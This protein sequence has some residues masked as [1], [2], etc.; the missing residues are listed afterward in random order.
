MPP[1]V[2][3]VDDS[4][5][6]RMDLGDAFEGAGFSP[7]LAS[8][9][10]ESR[11]ALE[12]RPYALVVLDVM[13]PDGDGLDLLREVKMG[14]PS[15]PVMLL[16]SEAEVAARLRG[17]RTGADEYVGKPYDMSYVL[18]RARQLIRRTSPRPESGGQILI[19]DDS[20]TFREQLRETLEGAGY[21]V[22]LSESGEEALHIAV[23]ARPAVIV[24]D[25]V[26]PGIDGATFIRRVREDAL[27]RRTP[28]ILLTASEGKGEVLALDSGANA[29]MQKDA[30][31]AQVL[32]R[33]GAVLRP[34]S[35]AQSSSHDASLHGPKKI[36]A[37]D[38]SM[39]YLQEI[40]TQLRRDGFHVVL[41]ASGEEAL[42]LL[43]ESEVDCILLDVLMP[44]LSGFETCRRIKADPRWRDVP[45]IMHTARD[46]QGSMVEGIDAGADD[47]VTKS[48]DFQV[49]RARL[50]AQL[51]RRQFEYE[52]RD[53]RETQIE[54][55]LE[56]AES[57]AQRELADSRAELLLEL[58]EKSKAL[59]TAQQN[60]EQQNLCVQAADRLKSEFLADMS[61]ELRSPLNAILGFTELL[62]DGHTKPDSPQHKEFLGHILAS[63]RHL[64]QLIEDALA[65]SKVEVGK[66]ELRPETVDPARVIGEVVAVLRASAAQT[67]NTLTTD[68]DPSLASVVVDAARFKQVVYIYVSNALKVT[69]PGGTVTV[70]LRPEGDTQ[71]CLEVQDNGIGVSSEDLEKLFVGFQEPGTGTTREFAGTRL[72]LAVTKRVVEAHGGRV[73]VRSVA[74][75]GSTF[76]AIMP[77]VVE[78]DTGAAT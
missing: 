51:R 55:A 72:G 33:I 69:P 26:L 74:G 1:S 8:T 46:E 32:A 47:Y 77:R 60:L 53:L 40:G 37:V 30:N 27:L 68:I 39:T 62:H 34:G 65:L 23:D 22:I 28:C 2:L 64:L 14:W 59:L 78:T 18:A 42:S 31:P 70:R 48:S 49:L 43:E 21:G 17:L 24:V 35:G 10:E 57:R 52:S 73:G 4:L 25:G 20:L 50:R 54:R 66:I 38:D 56:A 9:V 5:T 71:F 67:R 75:E 58:Q 29:Y 3:I 36:L 15:M 61:H 16:S 19:V 76:F 44:G 13:L 7:T 11:R 45:L 12:E 6:V 63:G 41:A